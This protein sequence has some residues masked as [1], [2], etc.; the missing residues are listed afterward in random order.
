MWPFKKKPK[1]ET[2]RYPYRSMQSPSSTSGWDGLSIIEK[3]VLI[4]SPIALTYIDYMIT[5]IIFD[6]LPNWV[7]ILIAITSTIIL[8]AG[9]WWIS[10]WMT[11]L[12]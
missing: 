7:V 6:Y 10:K 8:I 4:M 11:D 12:D 3:F 1:I 5:S 2:K 9:I